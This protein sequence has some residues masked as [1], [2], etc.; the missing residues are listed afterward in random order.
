GSGRTNVAKSPAS[1]AA[2]KPRASTG[3]AEASVQSPVQSAGRPMVPPDV[4]Q[5]FVP[6]R[7]K[8]SG[9]QSF[10]YIAKLYGAGSLNVSDPKSGLDTSIDAQ[11]LCEITNEPVPVNWD[12]AEAC[13]I[14][15]SD[16]EKDPSEASAAFAE[17][18][19]VAAQAKNYD[20]WTKD[21][22]NWL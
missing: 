18:P 17:L 8:V 4:T 15:S 12:D 16:L 6:V 22:A 9:P 3:E 5:Y 1:M 10:V 7:G 2:A 14:E 13:E 19:A 21:F 20:K 11:A